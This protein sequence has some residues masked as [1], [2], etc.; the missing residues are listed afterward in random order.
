MRRIRSVVTILLTALVA[1]GLMTPSG[2]AA[3]DPPHD[4]TTYYLALGDS[5]AYGYRP[6]SATPNISPTHCGNPN[7]ASSSRTSAARAK[8]PT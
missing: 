7:R 4:T 2:A 1:V 8:P 6:V 3:A 5:L